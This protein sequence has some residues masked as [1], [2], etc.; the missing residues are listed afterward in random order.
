MSCM[1]S[2]FLGLLLC[3]SRGTY[4]KCNDAGRIAGCAATIIPN[5]C[6]SYL[7]G[8]DLGNRICLLPSVGISTSDLVGKWSSYSNPTQ[9]QKLH[10]L[11]QVC[12]TFFMLITKPKAIGSSK[13]VAR[14]FLTSSFIGAMTSMSSRYR[15][16]L[17]PSSRLLQLVSLVL[18]IWKVHC[19]DRKGGTWMSTANLSSE[20][21]QTSCDGSIAE[22]TGRCLWDPIWSSN[23]TCIRGPWLSR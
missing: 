12:F 15:M 18:W 16:G 4:V 2:P 19:S 21:P 22:Q 9:K 5:T 17:I 10:H 7:T 13:A 3:L 1:L 11:I 23:L 6:A 20:R 14:C 8:P